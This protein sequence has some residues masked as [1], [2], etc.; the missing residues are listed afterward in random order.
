MATRTVTGT[1]LRPN[2]APMAFVDVR[3]TLIDN[4]YTTTPAATYPE[5]TIIEATDASGVLTVELVSGLSSAYYV[6][7]PDRNPFMI[8][9]EA[10]AATT[11]EAL[12]AETE[13][14]S[15]PL[16]SL[17]SIVAGLLASYTGLGITVQENDITKVATLGVLDFRPGFLVTE[18]PTG[19]ANVAPDT[20]TGATQLAPG[21]H[22]HT[23]DDASDVT[24]A[25]A[26][27]N[28]IVRRNSGNTA[29]VNGVEGLT[30]IASQSPS[31][32]TAVNFTSIFSSRYRNYLI[33]INLSAVSAAATIQARL[34]AASTDATAGNYE[35][36]GVYG[37]SSAV[38]VSGYN[39]T[40][41]TIW[42]LGTPAAG[43]EYRAVIELDDPQT[44]QRTS[45]MARIRLRNGTNTWQG[46]TLY[47]GYRL[48][49]QYDGISIIP[50]SGNITGEIR[51]YGVR[52]V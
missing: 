8:I 39:G 43:G 10:G 18:S 51:V 47:C 37:Q 15:L 3:F 2:G 12:R 31:A 49:T 40:A 29:W 52:D 19:E 26:V 35:Y 45:G 16:T 27:A 38:T 4:A 28:D 48:T 13:G 9:V 20:G 22:A 21:N 32:A 41:A 30:L 34:R 14:A 7:A 11:L 17:G 42:D 25:S 33:V 24:I 6:E 46:I 23:L 5:D 1:F 50:A 44:S 36:F